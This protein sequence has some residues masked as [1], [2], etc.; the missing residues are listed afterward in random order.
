MDDM[1]VKPR[2]KKGRDILVSIFIIQII[3][4]KSPSIQLLGWRAGE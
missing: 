1:C 3:N 4:T 2:Y